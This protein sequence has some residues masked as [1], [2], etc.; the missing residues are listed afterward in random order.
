M[1]WIPDPTHGL[2][3]VEREVKASLIER[4]DDRSRAS[5]W[6][7]DDV[8]LIGLPVPKNDFDPF[9]ALS[10]FNERCRCRFLLAHHPCPSQ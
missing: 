9:H 10:G 5:N 6:I 1:P 2:Y 3:V 8:A 7:S 4:V